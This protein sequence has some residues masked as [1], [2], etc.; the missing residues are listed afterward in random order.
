MKVYIDPAANIVYASYYIQGLY[1]I[2]GRSN[3]QFSMKP[4]RDLPK[5]NGQEDFDHYFAFTVNDRNSATRVAIDFRDK[6]HVNKTALAW[7]DVYGKVN[8]NHTEPGLKELSDKDRNKI[9]PVG[10]NFG[11][12]LWNPFVS[13]YYFIRNYIRCRFSPGISRSRFFHGYKWQVTRAD[14]DDYKPGENQEDYVFFVSTLWKNDKNSDTTNQLRAA[15]IRA[16]KALNIDFEGGL[17]T[18]GTSPATGYEDI[19]TR[20]YIH[21]TTFTDNIK[22]SAIVFNTPAVWGCHGWKLG[23]FLAMGK[24]IIS[25]A[26]LNEMPEPLKHGEH[27]HFVHTEAELQEAVQKIINDTAYRNKLETGAKNYYQTYI[28]PDI[29]IRKLLNKA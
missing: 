3:V 28:R 15:Y 21:H 23:E 18:N 11:V 14:I 6:A 12:R 29:V 8:Y 1:D 13:G 19:V 27:I 20:T 5:L 10:P 2:Y 9:V 16:C 22:K 17:F 24:A 26:F 25:T 7:C 4:F